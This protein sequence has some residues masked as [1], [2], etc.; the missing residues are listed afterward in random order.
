MDNLRN[1]LPQQFTKKKIERFWGISIQLNL[2]CT[3]AI[4]HV[5]E[6]KINKMINLHIKI[7]VTKINAITFQVDQEQQFLA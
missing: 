4:K 7:Y 6:A 1:C 5:K 2:R 3:I